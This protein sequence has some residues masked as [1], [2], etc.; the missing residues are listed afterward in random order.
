MA[1]NSLVNWAAAIPRAK[2]GSG[3]GLGR[4]AIFDAIP[5]LADAERV[6]KNRRDAERYHS[7]ISGLA[8]FD[9]A[10]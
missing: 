10:V 7:V 8:E 4:Y 9:R 1:V 6:Q 2:A 3:P 5:V